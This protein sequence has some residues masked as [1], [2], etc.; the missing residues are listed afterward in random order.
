VN[1]YIFA[2]SIN[3]VNLDRLNLWQGIASTRTQHDFAALPQVKITYGISRLTRISH[4]AP[5]ILLHKPVSLASSG[6]RAHLLIL[7]S[8]SNIFI[9]VLFGLPLGLFST[10]S[11]L[12][13]LFTQ[14]SSTFLST[15]PNHVNLFLLHTFCDWFHPNPSLSTCTSDSSRPSCGL[16]NS[17]LSIVWVTVK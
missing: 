16:R 7:S 5:W 6:D 4:F 8:S 17:S 1:F 2:K 11:N 15:C 14:S 13:H 10:T 9:H 3:Q 12:V